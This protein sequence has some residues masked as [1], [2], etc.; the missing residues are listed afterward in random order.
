M[1]PVEKL[2]QGGAKTGKFRPAVTCHGMRITKI[3]EY[4]EIGPIGFNLSH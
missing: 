1:G 4:K 2:K 3:E